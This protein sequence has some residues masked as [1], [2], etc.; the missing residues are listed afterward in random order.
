MREPKGEKVLN[1][2]YISILDETHEGT[3]SFHISQDTLM[4][5]VVIVSSQPWQW[6]AILS[7]LYLKTMPRI[8]SPRTHKKK[9][10][11]RKQKRNSSNFDKFVYLFKQIDSFNSI[12]SSTIDSTID[13]LIVNKIID[14]IFN[15]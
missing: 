8:S 4:E 6:K 5:S 12:V 15:N 13:I 10:I 11:K 3:P 1:C 14:N 7:P 2:S 9:G